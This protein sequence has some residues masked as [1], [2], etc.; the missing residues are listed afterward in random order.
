MPS[1][2]YVY[3]ILPAD[4]TLPAGLRGFHGAPVSV[5]RGGAVAATENTI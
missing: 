5:V 2:W 4:S 3:A 1:G